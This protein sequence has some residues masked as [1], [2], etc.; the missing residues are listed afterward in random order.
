MGVELDETVLQSAK[1]TDHEHT[2]L[3]F[4]TC[5]TQKLAKAF[6]SST[7][8]AITEASVGPQLTIE[9]GFDESVDLPESITAETNPNDEL[10]GRVAGAG[11][12]MLKDIIDLRHLLEPYSK[13]RALLVLSGLIDAQKVREILP[14][15]IAILSRYESIAQ[16]AP[17]LSGLG[18]IDEEELSNF[19]QFMVRQQR[20]C[21]TNF[22]IPRALTRH[23]LQRH[24]HCTRRG[25]IANREHGWTVPCFE[26]L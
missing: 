8:I 23:L 16:I 21:L 25:A 12:T 9:G 20:Y 22:F 19:T 2:G 17:E 11:A 10:W 14:A 4:C 5:N 1:H 13:K 26:T 24:K 18:I 6:A 3:S 7:D 15:T